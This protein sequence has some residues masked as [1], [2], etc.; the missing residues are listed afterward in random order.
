MEGKLRHNELSGSQRQ[1]FDGI[2][3]QEDYGQINCCKK[4]IYNYFYTLWKL[5]FYS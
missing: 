2:N 3:E 1:Y 4:I 5:L